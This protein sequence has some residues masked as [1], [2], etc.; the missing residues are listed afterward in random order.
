M[1]VKILKKLKKIDNLLFSD[2]LFI[3]GFFVNLG[4]VTA[5]YI[6]FSAIT[7]LAI[8]ENITKIWNV[9]IFTIIYLILYGLAFKTLIGEN[10]KLK[11]GF[12]VSNILILI[13]L[14]KYYITTLL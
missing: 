10:K 4:L 8:L 9:N 11:I 14:I 12:V 2:T 1:K 6:F 3:L 13:V 7:S 5:T